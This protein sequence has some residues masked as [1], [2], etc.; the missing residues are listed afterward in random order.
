MEY[1]QK[2]KISKNYAVNLNKNYIKNNQD[3]HLP[4]TARKGKNID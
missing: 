2:I 1:K 3:H 4:Q